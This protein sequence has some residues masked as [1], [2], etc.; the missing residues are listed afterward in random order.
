[1][2]SLFGIILAFGRLSILH[3]LEG[4]RKKQGA[5]EEVILSKTV[6]R[7]VIIA[8]LVRLLQTGLMKGDVTFRVLAMVFKD[9]YGDAVSAE[10]LD[11]LR[12]RG[13]RG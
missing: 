11:G 4:S 3:E 6:R 9:S 13:N 12:A 7:L 8:I 2:R 1:M 5:D 10:R